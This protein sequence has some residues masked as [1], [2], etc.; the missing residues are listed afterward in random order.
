MTEPTV[1]TGSAG[2]KTLAE[3]LDDFEGYAAVVASL[4]HGHSAAL[5]GVWGSS[6]ALVAANLAGHVSAA[7][8]PEKTNQS[9]ARQ[10]AEPGKLIVVCPTDGEIDDFCDDLANF[11]SAKVEKF[12]A[13]DSPPGERDVQ[14]DAHGQRLRILK[15][16]GMAKI[17]PMV[18]NA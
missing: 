12:P 5:G 15:L 6:C 13:W 11:S 7:D 14:D 17:L 8:R 1:E 3:R 16:L 18:P 4:T 2:L 9:R 10:E